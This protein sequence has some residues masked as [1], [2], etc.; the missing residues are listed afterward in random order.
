M[1]TKHLINTIWY[2]KSNFTGKWKTY[3]IGKSN[4]YAKNG[5][6]SF[7]EKQ[8]EDIR[9]GYD[10]KEMNNKFD[11][12]INEVTKLISDALIEFN[13]ADMQQGKS[14]DVLSNGSQGAYNSRINGIKEWFNEKGLKELKQINNEIINQFRIDAMESNKQ[15]TVVNKQ[16]ILLRFL[17]WCQDKHYIHNFNR[18]KII[19]AKQKTDV[20]LR[21]LSTEE[22][23]K[24]WSTL[25]EENNYYFPAIRFMYLLGLR[26]G[27]VVNIEWNDF[28]NN[29]E[30]MI[31]QARDGQKT[32]RNC[33]IPVHIEAQKI[34]AEQK[35]ISGKNQFVFLST[36]NKKLSASYLADRIKD[37]FDK[38]GIEDATSHTLR[39]T[40]ASQLV[41]KGVSLMVVRDLLRHKSIKETQIYA[42]LAPDNLSSAIKLLP[43]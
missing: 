40:F 42:H 18:K 10:L 6:K 21:F 32:K 22:L 1:A 26:V 13:K 36:K 30:F 28:I 7:T 8:V 31:T 41:M 5:K 12:P 25:K 34:L 15:N 24:L 16:R 33:S 37:I 27:D 19:K 17:D 2:V 9:K 20:K 35:K 29:N 43:I 3:Y 23:D 14:G 39:H 4:K 38:C 11:Q